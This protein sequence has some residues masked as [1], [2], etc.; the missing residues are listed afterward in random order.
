MVFCQT[1]GKPS[2]CGV[3][4]KSKGKPTTR[5][6]RFS[7][8]QMM[9][10]ASSSNAPRLRN[11]PLQFFG[12]LPIQSVDWSINGPN[13]KVKYPRS[14]DVLHKPEVVAATAANDTV[15]QN[16]SVKVAALCASLAGKGLEL[17]SLVFR[18]TCPTSSGSIGVVKN[19]DHTNPVGPSSLNRRRFKKDQGLGL[20][21]LAPPLQVLD[22]IPDD[23]RLVLQFDDPIKGGSTYWHREMWIITSK[24]P[25]VQ[26]PVDVLTAEDI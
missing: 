13:T 6:Q 10:A 7:R 19:Y 12:S 20:Q 8:S 15:A 11:D 5:S 23:T 9:N 21:F 25:T 1:C 17:H 22:D 18:F 14:F 4:H 3:K 24:L 26:I 2:P 16:F